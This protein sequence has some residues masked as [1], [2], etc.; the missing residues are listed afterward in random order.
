MA[1]AAI[2]QIHHFLKVSDSIATAGQPTEMQFAAIAEAGYRVVINL[3]LP[4]STNALPHEQVL[5]E[6]QDMTY[7]HIPVV[8]EEPTLADVQQFF[9]VMQAYAGTPVFVHCALNMRVSAFIYLYRR[10]Y[11]GVDEAAATQTLHQLWVPNDRW[12]AFIAQ[13]VQYYQ[14]H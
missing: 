13:V 12:Q 9:S 8:W 3:A 11:E 2:A 4:S 5:V 10:L 1:D 14:Q 7:I 6:A